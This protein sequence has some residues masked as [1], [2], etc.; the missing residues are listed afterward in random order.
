MLAEQAIGKRHNI[1]A[2]EA[3]L[4]AASYHSAALRLVDQP[5]SEVAIGHAAHG[6]ARRQ[7]HIASAPPADVGHEHADGPLLGLG[8]S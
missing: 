4:W 7:R 1:S 6:S 3:Y 2:R 5:P 8:G